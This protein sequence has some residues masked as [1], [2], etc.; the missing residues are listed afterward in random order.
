ME[1]YRTAE[2]RERIE[3]VIFEGTACKEGEGKK[4]TWFPPPITSY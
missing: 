3:Y 4:Y 1:D 2:H